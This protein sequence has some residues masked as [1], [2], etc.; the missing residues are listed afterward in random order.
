MKSTPLRRKSSNRLRQYEAEYARL[1]QEL[2]QTG[3]LWVGTIL[4]R[5]QPCGQSSC[6]CRQGP[7][8]YHGPYYFWTRKVRGKTV[9]RLLPAAEG[10]LYQN[11]IGNRQ[12]MH[13]LI[14]K[15]HAVSR[16]AAPFL[17]AA[18]ASGERQARHSRG[19]KRR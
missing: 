19:S 5:S 9:S 2:A 11:W 6:R 3:Y 10:Q 4:R 1:A 18:G 13:Q 15:M 7:K 16:K 17:L 12:R 14:D 8:F